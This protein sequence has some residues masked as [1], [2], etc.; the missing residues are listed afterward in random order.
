MS[1]QARCLAREPMGTYGHA[2]TRVAGADGTPNGWAVVI[3]DAGQWIV[4]KVAA[5]SE[6]F[7]GGADFD[8]VAVDV[9][10][11]LLDTYEMGGRICDRTARK[12]LGRR[13]SSVFPAP[14]RPVLA[15]KSWEDAC[16]RSRASGSAGKAISKQTFGILA[17]IKEIDCLLQRRR[18]LRD[19]VHEVHP[20]VSFAELVG[21]PM[22]HRKASLQGRE[23]RRRALRLCFPDQRMIEKAGRDQGLPIEDILDAT[24]A[25]WSALRL[26]RGTGRSLPAAI[27]R[28][29]TGLPMAIWV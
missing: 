4:R 22:G 24:V 19:V 16:Q 12:L 9:P 23:E 1:T 7:E 3:M 10:I 8:I 26:A 29:S 27:P 15:S 11:G 21:Q 13:S 25:C 17:K 5:L 28:D 14:V 18:A 20:E 2:M 6:I